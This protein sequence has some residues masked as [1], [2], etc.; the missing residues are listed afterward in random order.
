MTRIELAPEVL[1]D[2]DCILPHLKR[3]DS[4]NGSA[5]IVNAVDVLAHSPRI[6]RPCGDGLRELVIGTGASG[7]VALYQHLDTLDVVLVL[8]VR[9]QREAGYSN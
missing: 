4:D 6:G 3:H 9:S 7:F 2:F 5:R 8:V 1:A